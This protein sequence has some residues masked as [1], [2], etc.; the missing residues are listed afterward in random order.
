M[1]SNRR[2]RSSTLC[3]RCAPHNVGGTLYCATCRCVACLRCLEQDLHAHH[4]TASLKKAHEEL[5]EQLQSSLSKAE[6]ILSDGSMHSASDALNP[7]AGRLSA[8][9]NRV[10]R[11]AKQLH[12]AVDAFETSLVARLLQCAGT[13]EMERADERLAQTCFEESLRSLVHKLSVANGARASCKAQ[14]VGVAKEVFARAPP[15]MTLPNNGPVCPPRKRAR[16]EHLPAQDATTTAPVLPKQSIDLAND[17]HLAALSDALS[18]AKR[19]LRGLNNSLNEVDARAIEDPRKEQE[20]F[21]PKKLR[22]IRAE[23]FALPEGT[24][25]CI[26][27]QQLNVVRYEVLIGQNEKKCIRLLVEPGMKL[28]GANRLPI[29]IS[30]YTPVAILPLEAQQPT[31]LLAEC[32]SPQQAGP[33]HFSIYRCLPFVNTVSFIS[34]ESNGSLPLHWNGQMNL[35]VSLNEAHCVFAGKSRGTRDSHVLAL[36][37]LADATPIKLL[38]AVSVESCV[39]A[40]A[41]NS[42]LQ[43]LCVSLEHAIAV[44]DDEFSLLQRITCPGLHCSVISFIVTYYILMPRILSELPRL[45]PTFKG[46]FDTYKINVFEKEKHQQIPKLKLLSVGS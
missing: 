34:A 36:L 33:V 3:E 4:V 43:K 42:Q 41:Y 45:Q 6:Q 24:I 31:F 5:D 23:L 30:H 17:S 7:F 26:H 15:Q 46:M 29:F 22:R 16:R 1:P 18:S 25:T 11:K 21:V 32:I 12:R 9:V 14:L 10:H 44:F 20:H 27:M 19:L 38:H 37:E 2:S 28:D 8:L 35:L 40:L 39:Y 13:S